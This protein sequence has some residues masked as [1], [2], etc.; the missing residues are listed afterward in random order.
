MNTY[1]DLV[2]K[3]LQK[4][5]LADRIS[6]LLDVEGNENCVNCV[7][8]DWETLLQNNMTF[9]DFNTN[10]KTLW[11]CPYEP[12]VSNNSMMFENPL[13]AFPVLIAGY[14]RFN[15]QYNN[16]PHRP[17]VSITFSDPLTKIACAMTSD[18]GPEVILSDEFKFNFPFCNKLT[19][20]DCHVEAARFG[21]MGYPTDS[22]NHPCVRRT[23][24][25]DGKIVNP[26]FQHHLESVFKGSFVGIIHL[27]IDKRYSYLNSNKQ[28]VYRIGGTIEK[29]I[30]FYETK[31]M[32]QEEMIYEKSPVEWT[33]RKT[34]GEGE[35]EWEP[36][37]KMQKYESDETQLKNIFHDDD[38]D[39][40]ASMQKNDE[41]EDTSASLNLSNSNENKKCVDDRL[42]QDD[43]GTFV[44]VSELKL[45]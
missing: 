20:A 11:D 44:E 36:M 45:I 3:I 35:D 9:Q 18:L 25:F 30:A 23:E 43:D 8:P 2:A 27:L 16:Q 7:T 12:T 38:I 17:G 21:K 15:K 32:Y 29:L 22:N 42:F 24:V 19:C 41:M 14:C 13:Y 6:K 39:E 33:K 31:L 10:T 40:L 34:E 28:R 37:P 5:A 1:T 4:K 26:R